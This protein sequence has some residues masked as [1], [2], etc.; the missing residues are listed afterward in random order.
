MVFVRQ[1]HLLLRCEVALEERGSKP[2]SMLPEWFTQR[3]AADGR[4]CDDVNFRG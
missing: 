1:L 2:E 4:L 3:D